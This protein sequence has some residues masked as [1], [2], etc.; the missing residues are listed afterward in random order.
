FSETTHPQFRRNFGIITNRSG[1]F[2]V[3]FGVKQVLHRPAILRAGASDSSSG[4]P[5]LRNE[6]WQGRTSSFQGVAARIQV[7]SAAR[8]MICIPRQSDESE[9]NSIFKAA[10][11]AHSASRLDQALIAVGRYVLFGLAE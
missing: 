11:R 1:K 4:T 7:S 9:G 10:T 2:L 3:R 6:F 5:L 8:L